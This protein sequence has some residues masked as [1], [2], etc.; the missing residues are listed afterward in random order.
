VAER[1]RYCFI[2]GLAAQRWGEPR[3]TVNVGVTILTGFGGETPFVTALLDRFESR[4]RMQ[5][6]LRGRRASC[7]C[8][9]H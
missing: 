1:W 8:A 6:P 2:G 3:E 5:Q 4:I 7:S 9:R